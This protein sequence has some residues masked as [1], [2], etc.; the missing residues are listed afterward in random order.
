MHSNI[1]CQSLPT[2]ARSPTLPVNCTAHFFLLNWFSILGLRSGMRRAMW[3][4]RAQSTYLYRDIEYRAVSG[5]FRNIDPQ[6]PLH[7]AIV[8]SPRTQRRGGGYTFSGRWGG[9]GSIF[10]KTP[11]IGL[12][13]YSIIPLR[14]RGH[15]GAE[16]GEK[17][18]W[19][20]RRKSEKEERR[21][22]ENKKIESRRRKVK[23]RENRE[24]GKMGDI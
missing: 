15:Q 5:V 11:D 10:R 14:V 4:V 7:P 3:E 22:R 9:G 2:G 13:S 21:W 20:K 19:G 18:D 1:A 16:K 6:P 8:S 12:A 23:K 24:R 17:G